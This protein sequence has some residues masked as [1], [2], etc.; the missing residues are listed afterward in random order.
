MLNFNRPFTYFAKLRRRFAEA[1]YVPCQTGSH[2]MGDQYLG[3][4][5]SA[6]VEIKNFPESGRQPFHRI[7]INVRPPEDRV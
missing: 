2:D 4:F 5:A 6:Y 7:Q 1:I 3:D